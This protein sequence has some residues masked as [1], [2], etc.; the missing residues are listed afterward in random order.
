MFRRTCGD[1][2]C[3]LFI[4]HARLWV[5][6]C[7]RHSLR[8]PFSEGGFGKARAEDAAAGKRSRECSQPAA[9]YAGLTPR[10]QAYWREAF[11]WIKFGHDGL[12]GRFETSA[13]GHWPVPQE[14]RARPG[15]LT[16]IATVSDIDGSIGVGIN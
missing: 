15:H 5:R 14:I 13:F 4:S 16:R 11:L 10:I 1:Y 8:P 6:P 3:V 9:S 7:T 2:T 12:T